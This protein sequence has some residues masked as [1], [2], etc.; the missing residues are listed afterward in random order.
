MTRK[1]WSK[2][3]TFIN[4]KI[5]KKMM[6]KVVLVLVMAV[7]SHFAFAQSPA[8]VINAFKDSPKAEFIELPK[9]LLKMAL[10]DEENAETSSFINRVD[11]MK[12]LSVPADKKT[13]TSFLE[14]VRKMEKGGFE[15]VIDMVEEGSTILIYSKTKGETISELVLAEVDNEECEMI[16][17]TG[18]LKVEDLEMLQ[19][20]DEGDE[21]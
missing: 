17:L 3:T 11:N 2:Y 5:I 14:K 6:K 15:K 18:N 20:L 12:M 9:A 16:Y 19:N 13:C 1:V 4:P 8:D 21:E 7:C 10:A